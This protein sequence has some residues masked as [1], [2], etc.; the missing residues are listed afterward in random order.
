MSE[1]HKLFCTTLD[2]FFILDKKGC[3]LLKFV[4]ILTLTSKRK[5]VDHTKFVKQTDNSNCKIRGND[6][7]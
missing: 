6:D 4:N 7:Q 2:F 3:N 1:T 5:V